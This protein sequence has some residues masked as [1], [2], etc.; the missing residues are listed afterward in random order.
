MPNPNSNSYALTVGTAPERPWTGGRNPDGTV[1]TAPPTMSA[2]SPAASASAPAPPPQAA[3]PGSSAAPGA[4]GAI[5][6]LIAALAQAFAPKAL[7]QRKAATNQAIDKASG[8]G[9]LGDQ[10]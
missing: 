2:F 1:Q 6:A 10:F 4:T 9:A 3:T 7:T 8:G 5:Q